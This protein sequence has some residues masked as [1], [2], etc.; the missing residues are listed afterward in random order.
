MRRAEDGRVRRGDQR[1]EQLLDTAEELFGEIGYAGT[2]LRE[3][4]KRAGITHAGLLRHYASKGDL[5]FAVLQR[6]AARDPLDLPDPAATPDA[7]AALLQLA[8]ARIA[9]RRRTELDTMLLGEATEQ[10]HPGRPFIEQRLRAAGGWLEAMYPDR[11]EDVLAAWDGLQLLSLYLPERIS[12]ADTLAAGLDTHANRRRDNSGAWI[13]V[14][15]KEVDSP[16]GIAEADEIPDRETTILAAAAKMFAHNGFHA[17]SLRAISTEL[18]LSH[19]TLLYYFDSKQAL[20]EAVLDY[21]ARVADSVLVDSPTG[22]DVLYNVYRRARYNETRPELVALYSVLV[23]EATNPAHPAHEYFTTR[24]S[25]LLDRAES[26]ITALQEQGVLDPDIAPK[27]EA[28]WIIAL[29]DGL[30][31]HQPYG[32]RDIPE[33]LLRNLNDLVTDATPW[34][35]AENVGTNR[36][37]V[38]R[39]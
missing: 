31:L 6:M 35:T 36:V 15:V 8:D 33:R 25:R 28:P 20:L 34:S 1:R 13:A 17:T 7:R 9:N 19:G 4:A 18:G 30:Q 14:T 21:R 26:E 37:S 38:V 5:L 22:Y 24:Y 39:S 12:P 32:A 29:W 10:A 23:C 16:P 3:L 11:G 2:S 27:H